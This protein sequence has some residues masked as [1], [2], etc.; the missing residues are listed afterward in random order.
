MPDAPKTLSVSF[1][2]PCSIRVEIATDVMGMVTSAM[3]KRL[4]M[5]VGPMSFTLPKRKPWLKP[6]P[7]SKTNR[8]L[9]EIAMDS[10]GTL[11]LLL[12]A[13]ARRPI[14]PRSSPVVVSP[15]GSQSACIGERTIPAAAT[16]VRYLIRGRLVNGIVDEHL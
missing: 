12:N 1:N 3:R 2:L 11:K 5:S 9:R 14:S 15:C 8:P 13:A 16:L 7:R 10:E 4:D 6:N